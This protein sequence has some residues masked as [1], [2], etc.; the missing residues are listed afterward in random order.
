MTHAQENSIHQVKS[1]T[2]S[3]ENL[4]IKQTTKHFYVNDY[5]D[6]LCYHSSMEALR[7]SS[8]RSKPNIDFI[9]TTKPT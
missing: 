2:N 8:D 6:I 7:D 5:K 1:V 4:N 9:A 3:L